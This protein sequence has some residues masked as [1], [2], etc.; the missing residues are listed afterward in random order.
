MHHMVCSYCYEINV[1]RK[2]RKPSM[3]YLFQISIGPVQ[4]FITGARRT[5]DLKFS[6]SFL[7]RLA[8]KAASTLAE[9]CGETSLIF[10]SMSAGKL[11]DVPNKIL[12]YIERDILPATLAQI[13]KQ[14]I[15]EEVEAV[16][17]N[18]FEKIPQRHFD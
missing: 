17:D 5:R 2:V 7:S 10:P 6:S 11:D 16:R 1:V 8:R 3:P 9:Q 14:T 13:I 4:S 18:V 12:A 15:D